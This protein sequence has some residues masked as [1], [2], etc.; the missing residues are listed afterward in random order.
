MSRF[1]NEQVY[2]YSAFYRRLLDEHHIDPHKIRSV[3]DL[4]RLPFTLKKD[5]VPTPDNPTRPI[6]LVLRPDKELIRKYAPRS[7]A[8][9]LVLDGLRYG[10]EAV[11]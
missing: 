6:D 4:R 9:K 7:V 10:R 1:I 3:D 11:E 8:V 2:P 5:I